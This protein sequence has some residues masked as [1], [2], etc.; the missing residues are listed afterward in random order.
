MARVDES[1]LDEQWKDTA[2]RLQTELT[3]FG[4]EAS[5]E[6]G[7]LAWVLAAQ[8]R[9]ETDFRD[10]LEKLTVLREVTHV[11]PDSFDYGYY[12]YGMEVYG[13]MPL[14]EENEFREE[15][16]ISDLVIAI[17][18]SASSAFSTKPPRSSAGGRTSSS[19]SACTSSSAT[20]V[21]RRTSC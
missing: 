6:T 4:A 1:A 3:T 21:C 15:R 12:N 13:N 8:Y 10:F 17:D 20:T 5:D 14:I 19:G 16:R 11:D 7:S 18:T 2:E 9:Q